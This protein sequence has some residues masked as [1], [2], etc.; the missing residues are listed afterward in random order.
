MAIE[1]SV[2][3][4]TVNR[5]ESLRATLRSLIDQTFP[6]AAY[7]V[8]V[9]DNGTCQDTT[10]AVREFQAKHAT[11]ELVYVREVRRGHSNARNRGVQMARGSVIVFTDDDAQP[12]SEWLAGLLE[13]FKTM[14]EVDAVGGPVR[15]LEPSPPLPLWLPVQLLEILAIFDYGPQGRYLRYPLSLFGV[16]MAIRRSVFEHV[17]RFDPLLGRQGSDSWVVG[18]ETDLLL[19]LEQY[20]GIIYYMPDAVVY[21]R[22]EPDRLQKSWFYAQAYGQGV[23]MGRLERKSF[24]QTRV[25]IW[26]MVSCFLMAV[27]AFAW[28]A[29]WLTRREAWRVLIQCLVLRRS[30]YVLGIVEEASV[31]DD[32]RAPRRFEM[33][34][35]RWLYRVFPFSLSGDGVIE[36]RPSDLALSVVIPTHG[37]STDAVPAASLQQC[38]SSVARQAFPQGAMELIVVEDGP[39][40]PAIRDVVERFRERLPIHHVIAGDAHQPL[41]WLR[42]LGL[43]HARGQWMLLMDDDSILA[44]DFLQQLADGLPSCDAA[45]EILLPRRMPVGEQDAPLACRKGR[46]TFATGCIVYPRQLLQR[47]RGF[48]SA[49]ECFED[50]DIALRALLAGARGRRMPPLVFFN[51]PPRQRVGSAP[52]KQRAGLYTAAYQY[53]W[54]VYSKPVWVI[55]VGDLLAQVALLLLPW[56]RDGRSAAVLAWHI[57]VGLGVAVKGHGR[58]RQTNDQE[59][60]GGRHGAIVST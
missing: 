13:V 51:S 55:V 29:A 53:V 45:G 43:Q 46:Y 36:S 37:R 28:L 11:P 27:G 52:T 59:A 56:G 14:P 5:P 34:I 38:L 60:L 22:I 31:K 21:H 19:R 6:R 42:N 32:G 30:G 3:V 17:G 12:H 35:L 15:P 33:A 24:S 44:D 1:A 16:N 23:S 40:N 7:E 18:D 54:H 58:R 48:H 8:I 50:M 57:L 4:C 39:A 25:V 26:A 20:G 2:V 41:G 49:L 47:I 10:P 9:V